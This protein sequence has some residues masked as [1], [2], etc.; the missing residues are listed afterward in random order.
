M[1]A[2]LLD[3]NYFHFFRNRVNW[4]PDKNNERTKAGHSISKPSTLVK[5]LDFDNVMFLNGRY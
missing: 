4:R 3:G 5:V 2:P 1:C